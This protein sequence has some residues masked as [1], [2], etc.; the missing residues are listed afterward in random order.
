M[1]PT[2]RRAWR[3]LNAPHPTAGCAWRATCFPIPCG[4]TARIIRTK[5]AR[6]KSWR[7]RCWRRWT[8]RSTT[9]I[10]TAT[11]TAIWTPLC[12]TSRRAIRIL[13]GSA[14]RPI[15]TKI[16]ILR[17]TVCVPSTTLS[18]TRSPMRTGGAWIIMS[19]SCAMSSG[20]A[21]VCRIIT[22]SISMPRKR[23]TRPM[24]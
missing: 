17:W 10:T 1:I 15:G 12:S 19:A 11:G 21:W 2:M 3:R 5:A 22:T 16:Q 18:T 23:R 14:A 20:I 13:I 24:G 8:G 4:R 6:L 9:A 7:W